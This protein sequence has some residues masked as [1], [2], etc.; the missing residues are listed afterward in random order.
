MTEQASASSDSESESPV[1]SSEE[2][3]SSSD[4]EE[5][6]DRSFGE[7]YAILLEA[8]IPEGA[9]CPILCM[10]KVPGKIDRLKEELSKKEREAHQMTLTKKKLLNTTH[11]D[12]SAWDAE[13]EKRLKKK[14]LNGVLALFNANSK[15][16]NKP[17]LLEPVKEEEA[18]QKK[19]EFLDLLLQAASKK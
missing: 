8:P 13:D 11:K 6:T 18:P 9:K 2:E 16:Q 19:D 14:T 10:S 15:A 4:V 1:L 12:V 5:P 7:Q 3:L 17:E